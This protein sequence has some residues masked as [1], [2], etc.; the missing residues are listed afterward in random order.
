MCCPLHV[1]NLL[2]LNCDMGVDI[3]VVKQ[4]LMQGTPFQLYGAAPL[5]A[6]RSRRACAPPLSPP[7]VRAAPLPAAR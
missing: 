7:R 1:V 6:A 5:P 4:R 2:R 3:N